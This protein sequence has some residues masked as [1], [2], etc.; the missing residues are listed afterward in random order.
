MNSFKAAT[1]I[2]ENIVGE[3]FKVKGITMYAKDPHSVTEVALF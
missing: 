3:F 1:T 2:R